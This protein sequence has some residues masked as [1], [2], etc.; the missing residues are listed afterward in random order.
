[1]QLAKG[2][3]DV[4]VSFGLGFVILALHWQEEEMAEEAEEP[5]VVR[6]FDV[7]LGREMSNL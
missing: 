4:K 5:R 1:M 7:F 3:D 2:A 6:E